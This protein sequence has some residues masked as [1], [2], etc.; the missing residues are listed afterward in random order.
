MATVKLHVE[1]EDAD[2]QA[3]AIAQAVVAG[4]REFARDVRGP[5]L[6]GGEWVVECQS[7]TLRFRLRLRP[8]GEWWRLRIARRR[9]P[10]DQAAYFAEDVESWDVQIVAFERRVLEMASGLPGVR[11]I[12]FDPE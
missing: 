8:A 10:S 7:G 3:A 12:D 1:A 5:E 11:E 2:T 4:L 6:R 9:G